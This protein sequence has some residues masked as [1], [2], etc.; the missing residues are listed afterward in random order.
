MDITQALKKR[1][2]LFAEGG[3][4]VDEGN[5]LCTEGRKLSIEGH[6]LF[7]LYLK[8]TKYELI[9]FDGVKILLINGVGQ[10]TGVEL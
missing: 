6:Y 3:R 1:A 9:D 5:K 2:K 4:L 7:T 10:Y 8:D